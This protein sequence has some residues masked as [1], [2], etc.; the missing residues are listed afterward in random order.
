M[1]F[2]AKAFNQAI[3]AWNTAKVTS[4]EFIF[5]GATAFNQDIGNWNAAKVTDFHGFH[6]KDRLL[7]QPG[8]QQLECHRLHPTINTL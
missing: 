4:M 3:S 8:R 7:I 1:F 6:V 2:D 5:V